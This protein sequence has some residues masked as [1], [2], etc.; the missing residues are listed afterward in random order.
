MWEHLGTTT[1]LDTSGEYKKIDVMLV[2]KQLSSC[3]VEECV[4]VLA[5]IKIYSSS[6][7]VSDF[8]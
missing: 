6:K 3:G 1:S 2:R 7:V 4:L 8:L 5:C